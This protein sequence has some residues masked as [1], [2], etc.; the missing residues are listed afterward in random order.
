MLAT[1]KVISDFVIEK[2]KKKK[3]KFRDL[4][5][6]SQ[7]VENSFVRCKIIPLVT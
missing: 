4:N 6:A 5:F 1:S 7:K 2:K 3:K